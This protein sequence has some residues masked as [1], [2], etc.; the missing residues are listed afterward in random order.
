MGEAII[1]KSREVQ[2][3][4]QEEHGRSLSNAAAKRSNNT[5]TH[6][7]V[8]SIGKV[9][10]T[11]YKFSHTEIFNISFSSSWMKMDSKSMRP[12]LYQTTGVCVWQ[13]KQRN[14]ISAPLKFN[15][16]ASCLTTACSMFPCMQR[17]E[18]LT[19]QTWRCNVLMC[20]FWL[21]KIATS[22]RPYSYFVNASLSRKQ[23]NTGSIRGKKTNNWECR[24][25]LC[26]VYS[27][28]VPG[29]QQS[30]TILPSNHIFHW[31]RRDHK[32]ERGRQKRV[33]RVR[34]RKGGR[35]YCVRG[36]KERRNREIGS[37]VGEK[38]TRAKLVGHA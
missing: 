20:M 38:E 22:C 31:Y 13:L 23:V 17:S 36:K 18:H 33:E 14:E 6:L 32:K 19:P 10:L 9:I 16:A 7:R 25:T 12:G 29:A 27:L 35:G 1:H 5:K 28:M 11:F 3:Q 26:S 21:I 24:C 4:R 8:T 2:V 34:N 30:P 15:M 37:S